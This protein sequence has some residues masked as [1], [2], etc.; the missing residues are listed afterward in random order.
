MTAHLSAAW[1]VPVSVAPDAL[2]EI[3]AEFSREWLRICDEA[4]RGILSAPAD[5]RFASPAWLADKRHLLMAHAYLLSARVLH[6][7]VEAAQ[8]SEHL[9]SRLR[10][11]IMQ[12]V[13]ALSPANFLAFNPDAQ[14]SIVETA[15]R[16]LNAGLA[17]LM[18]DL[19]K[20]RI[21]QT[22]ES[23]F[24][25][26][27]NVAVTPGEVVYE[28]RLMQ[29]IQYAPQ[30]DKVYERPLVVVPPNI[31][32]YYILDLQP[33]NSFVRHAVQAGHTVF[34]VSWR[35]PLS[36]DRD[37]VDTATWSDYLD[38][39]VLKALSVASDITGQEQV[40][41][42]GFC[43]GG[44]ML[45]AALALADARGEKPVAAL[46]LLTS[47]LD[48]HDTG[49]LKVFVD[50]GHALLRDHQLGQGGLMSARDL[51][52][53]FSFLR[54]NELVWNYVVA[55]YLKGQTPPAFDL[56]FWNADSTN[57][58][59]PFFSW[60]FRNTYL[61]NNLKVPGVAQAAGTP[62]D[63]SRLSMPAYIYGSREDHIVPWQSAY[64]STQ[65]LRGPMRFVLGASGHIAGV[66]NPPAKKRR[67]FWA[68]ESGAALPGDPNAWLARAVEHP[69][70]WWPD[71]TQ[72]LAGHAGKQVAAR[73]KLGSKKYAPIEP[74][75]GRYVKVRAV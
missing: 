23:Q 59:G 55:N 6:R 40:N 2:A 37:G 1:P 51:A 50:E 62:L 20:G 8:V 64:A 38:E 69:G 63:L 56:L 32:K 68:D 12:W 4:Q 54:P 30:T 33:E 67:S 45:A 7:M 13:D 66:V 48:F 34:I 71:W 52:T 31:N 60:Y 44:T 26:G 46:T 22:D 43:V 27:R 73:R 35:N 39:A 10:F 36:S 25:I 5:K 75:P 42:L 9:R 61:E 15:G 28:N 58:P 14:Q 57:L 11:S 74:A 47:L 19:R 29:L 65:L 16:A 17:N 18:A 24:E 21:T 41:G 3:Q 70:S 49:V 72:W 53:T